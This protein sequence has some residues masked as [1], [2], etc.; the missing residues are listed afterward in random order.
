[1]L[2]DGGLE[3]Q[4]G[5]QFAKSGS[6]RGLGMHIAI[7]DQKW[8]AFLVEYLVGDSSR[9][10][11]YRPA[12][13]RVGVG[14]FGFA[15]IKEARAQSIHRD[16]KHIAIAVGVVAHLDIGKISIDGGR[17]G[18]LPV[19][20]GT[21]A[22]GHCHLQNLAGI[23]LAAAH[24]HQI[25]VGAEVARAHLRV[26]LIAAGAENDRA[27]ARL[28]LFIGVGNDDAFDSALVAEQ[29]AHFR[30]IANLDSHARGNLA[31]LPELS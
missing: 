11:Q 22:E 15:L 28:V 27:A 25:G 20:R 13:F 31:P 26:G 12:G 14:M 1:V 7:R 2:Q 9:L 3:T 18:A 10:P 24:L 4:L 23:V 5:R 17:M 29:L 19:A 8:Q 21:R 16:A 6:F 30:F